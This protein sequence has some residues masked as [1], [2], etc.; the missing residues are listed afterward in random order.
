VYDFDKTVNL[1]AEGN[2]VYNNGLSNP[3]VGGEAE[4]WPAIVN[5]FGASNIVI[6]NNY[7]AE[8]YGE[9]IDFILVRGG[10]AYGNV[11][12]DNFSVNIYLD[13]AS[14]VVVDS[15]FV[16]NTGNT[17]FYRDGMP[18]D[19]VRIAQED[20]YDGPQNR[21]QN[22]T[23]IN[24][25]I[26]NTGS[27]FFYNNYMVTPGLIDTLVANN[28]FVGAAHALLYID[29]HRGTTGSV[30]ENNVF[31]Q[32][33]AGRAGEIPSTA[34][35]TFRN[36]AW[37]GKLDGRVVGSGDVLEDPKL[38]QPGEPEPQAYRPAAGSP[39]IDR[40][41]V[42]AAVVADFLGT[43]RPQGTTHDIG[44]FEVKP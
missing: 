38:L 43:A 41:V 6:A 29:R 16:F 15:N 4:T 3:R 19:G 40:G 20:V 28:T 34:G 7:I 30:F 22:N 10:L 26:V 33:G 2:L 8:N 11:V 9:G 39:L 13:N 21:S 12:V 37:F 23:I 31:L 17:K 24:N 32:N 14:D 1:R 36:N 35:L 18:A 42:S 44:A 25:I 27:G 5:G